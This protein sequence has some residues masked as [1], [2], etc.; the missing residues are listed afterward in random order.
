LKEEG[1]KWIL[2]KI[3]SWTLFIIFFFFPRKTGSVTSF[4]GAFN[5]PNI[6]Q[7]CQNL[8]ET[9]HQ[10]SLYI[11]VWSSPAHWQIT[12]HGTTPKRPTQAPAAADLT[13]WQCTMPTLS[14]QLGSFPSETRAEIFLH[15]RQDC[16]LPPPINRGGFYCLREEKIKSKN[17]KKPASPCFHFPFFPVS[18]LQ[19]SLHLF[20]AAF[21]GKDNNK[22]SLYTTTNTSSTKQPPRLSLSSPS[23]L[24]LSS[25]NF[26]FLRSSDS[27]GQALHQRRHPPLHQHDHRPSPPQVVLHPCLASTAHPYCSLLLS[28]H[29]EFILHAATKI[30]T[31]GPRQFWPHP[32][33][34]AGFGPTPIF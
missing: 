8:H 30:I 19:L 18:L 3:E 4:A 1:L 12:G 34:W 31:F 27:A 9:D 23:G 13:I 7:I 28:L 6:H 26:F 11:G 29:A 5:A 24:F 32:N 16:P 17:H 15:C 20:T 2:A 21:S 33:G 14:Q 10:T 22:P 25:A